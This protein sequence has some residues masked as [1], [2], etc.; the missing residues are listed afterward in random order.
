MHR[1][2]STHNVHVQCTSNTPQVMK[3]DRFTLLMKFLHLNDSKHYIQKG[4]PSHD[5]PYKLRPFLQPLI[6]NF[7]QHY[8]L[9]KEISVDETITFKGRL[10]FIQ[11]MPEKNTK[12]GL[13]AFVLSDAHN[14]YMYT[15]KPAHVNDMNKCMYCNHLSVLPC[16]TSERYRK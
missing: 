16:T 2:Y 15:G 11:Y 7:Q 3:R 9:H 13:K 6:L 14:G 4:Q 12:W 5:A 1:M 8:V 10:G